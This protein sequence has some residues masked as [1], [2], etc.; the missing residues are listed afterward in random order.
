MT[1]NWHWPA[2]FTRVPAGLLFGMAGVHKVF[3]MTPQVHAVMPKSVGVTCMDV[4]LVQLPFGET[5]PLSAERGPL[6]RKDQLRSYWPTAVY[7][8]HGLSDVGA[9]AS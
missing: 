3:I 6:E 9:A 5:N 1:F 8:N 4:C 7:L 2:F